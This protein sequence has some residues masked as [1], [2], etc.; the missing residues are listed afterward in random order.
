MLAMMKSRAAALP[1]SMPKLPKDWQRLTD[2][3]QPVENP[4]VKR[5]NDGSL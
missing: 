2:R 1:K 4:V 3:S 5:R